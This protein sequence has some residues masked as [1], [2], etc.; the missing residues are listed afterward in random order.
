MSLTINHNNGKFTCDFTPDGEASV[1]INSASSVKVNLDV[2]G[3]SDQEL[4]RDNEDTAEREEVTASALEELSTE[5]DTAES[6]EV[7]SST[8][9]ELSTEED[10]AES[11][12]ATSSVGPDI[13]LGDSPRKKDHTRNW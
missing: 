6:E 13:Y 4:N 8:L 3:L 11:E 7:T 1:Q 12:E 10:T 5:E 2:T 9:E